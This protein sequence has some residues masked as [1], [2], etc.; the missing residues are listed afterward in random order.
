MMDTGMIWL[1]VLEAVMIVLTVIGATW[2]LSG[3]ISRMAG[4]IDHLADR[5]DGMADSLVKYAETQGR[6]GEDIA[7]LKSRVDA[8]EETL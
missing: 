6:H 5:V 2:A 3:N 8:I 7:V 4:S 1:N